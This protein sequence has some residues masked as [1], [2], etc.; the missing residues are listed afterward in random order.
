MLCL[1]SHLSD[2][3][4]PTGVPSTNGQVVMML[5]CDFD[6][7]VEVLPHSK[8]TRRDAVTF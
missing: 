1:G 4:I 5:I 3:N 2:H 6:N 7:I 8:M